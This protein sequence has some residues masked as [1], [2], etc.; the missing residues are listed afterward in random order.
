[1]NQ[2]VKLRERV[3]LPRLYDLI[4]DLLAVG[5]GCTTLDDVDLLVVDFKDAFKQLRVKE[6]EQRFISGQVEGGWFAYNRLLFGIVSGPL[7]WGRV[8]AL[9]MRATASFLDPRSCRLQCYVDDPVMVVRGQPEVRKE[10]IQLVVLWWLLLGFPLSWSKA[11]LGAN[12]TWIGASIRVLPC[13]AAFAVGIPKDKT[14]S[15][16]EP[17]HAISKDQVADKY[18]IEKLAGKIEWM[19]G[20]LPQL[21]PFNQMLWAALAKCKYQQ[22]KVYYKQIQIAVRWLLAFA[23]QRALGSDR[24]FHLPQPSH[25]IVVA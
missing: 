14:D 21:K 24:I 17:L 9:I 11:Q 4:Q 19:A 3:I 13:Q 16:I 12:V 22:R 20:A 23:A 25:F 2:K 6:D 8:A 5:K 18:V 1:M 10:V 15:L 7:L